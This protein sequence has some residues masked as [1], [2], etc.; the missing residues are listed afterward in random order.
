VERRADARRVAVGPQIAKPGLLKEER[1]GGERGLMG[2]KR[3]IG[4]VGRFY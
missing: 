3:I 1:N 2:E 4:R